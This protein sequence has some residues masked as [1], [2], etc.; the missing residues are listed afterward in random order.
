[1]VVS[2]LIS[3]EKSYSVETSPFYLST[4]TILDSFYK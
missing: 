1:M 3:T 4:N 2:H